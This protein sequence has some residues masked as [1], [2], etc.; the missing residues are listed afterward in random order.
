MSAAGSK[1]TEISDPPR[2]V[3]ERTRRTPSTV[4]A[5]SSS[6]RVT[7]SCI[8]R[9]DRSPACATIWIRGNSTSG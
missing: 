9:G 1:I 5:A 2:I 6:G 7:A 3:F 8:M 4:R